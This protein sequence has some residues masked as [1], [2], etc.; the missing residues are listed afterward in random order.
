MSLIALMTEESHLLPAEESSLFFRGTHAR[1][2]VGARLW[3]KEG[4]RKA[5]K[6]LGFIIIRPLSYK[7]RIYNK[8]SW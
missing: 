5:P 3:E 4:A 2:L 6:R 7:G 8:A 1:R